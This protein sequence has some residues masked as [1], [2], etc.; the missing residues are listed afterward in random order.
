MIKLFLKCGVFSSIFKG[1]YRLLAGA[2][3][4]RLSKPVLMDYYNKAVEEWD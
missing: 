1:S 3:I 2:E 4:N